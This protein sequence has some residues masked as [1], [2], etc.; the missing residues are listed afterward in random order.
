VLTDKHR[1]LTSQI[2]DFL[3]PMAVW[4]REQPVGWMIPIA[5][6]IVLSF[7]PLMGQEVIILIVG[8]VWGLWIGFGIVTAGTYLG[9][10]ANYYLFKYWLRSRAEELER[11]NVN[12]QALAKI[13]RDGGFPLAFVIRL[14]ACPG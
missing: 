9:E 13:T 11:T 3:E 6:L 1:Q 12:Y 14:S 2:I 7:P 5:A 4:M 10:L 8:I